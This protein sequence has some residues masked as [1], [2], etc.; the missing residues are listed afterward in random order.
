M[1]SNRPLLILGSTL[2]LL[3]V[4]VCLIWS[5][6]GPKE[7][8]H[9]GRPLT[10]WISE[11]STEVFLADQ[12]RRAEDAIRQIGTNALPVIL[13][14]LRVPDDS[15]LARTVHEKYKHS[16]LARKG[17]LVQ[18]PHREAAVRRM[19]AAQALRVLAE[20]LGLMS[21]TNLLHDPNPHVQEAAAEALV[22]GFTIEGVEA[23]MEALGSENVQVRLAAL[24]G[25]P[26][27]GYIPQEIASLLRCLAEPNPQMRMRAALCLQ[28]F[29][30]VY[31][32]LK[33]PGL[34][35]GLERAAD[36]VDPSVRATAQQALAGIRP[37]VA[38]EP[39]SSK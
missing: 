25:L 9:G 36:D 6:F 35:E 12:T 1:K 24:H 30:P 34:I 29:S 7:P 39:A 11:L 18:M 16:P 8:I 10:A 38:L 17:S 33:I 3:T 19:Q 26:R 14:E 20:P 4:A 28:Q 37:V 31:R 23:L 15:A 13:E 22:H 5:D 21:L 32:D 27:A 2:A